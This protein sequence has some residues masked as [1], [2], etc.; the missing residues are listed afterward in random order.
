[1]FRKK[2]PAGGFP[3]HDYL[4]PKTLMNHQTI[5]RHRA[6]IS[7]GGPG[8]S[9]QPGAAAAQAGDPEANMIDVTSKALDYI[10]ERGGNLT[11]YSKTL[12]G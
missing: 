6:P 7:T 1:M 2:N 11:L 10:A 12:S 8:G 5:A 4:W 9:R 3:L